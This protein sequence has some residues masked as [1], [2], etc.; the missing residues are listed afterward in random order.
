MLSWALHRMVWWPFQINTSLTAS[1]ISP[2]RV[3]WLWQRWEVIVF[4]CVAGI[5]WL[6]VFL[7]IRHPQTK[8][9]ASGESGAVQCWTQR[10][11]IL[12]LQS[13]SNH[14]LQLLTG[15]RG[16]GFNGGAMTALRPPIRWIVEINEARNLI[17]SWWRRMPVQRAISL[18]GFK[19]DP[20]IF[21]TL[22][23]NWYNAL[24]DTFK[25]ITWE[26]ARSYTGI[27]VAINQEA[28]G[29][30]SPRWSLNWHIVGNYWASLRFWLFFY[31]LFI[32][33]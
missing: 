12:Y 22:F 4:A 19:N 18:R 8:F 31:M 15:Y 11:Q 13:L 14:F 1:P 29:P 30:N 25:R 26:K 20:L 28:F 10:S 9:K 24:I 16:G 33:W 23:W 6:G 2:I 7:L 21:P 17:W 3:L 5:M 32:I 27:H